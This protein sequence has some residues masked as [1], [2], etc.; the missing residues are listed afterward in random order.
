MTGWI[1]GL[2]LMPGPET[3][4]ILRVFFLSQAS[5]C[6][7]Q[8]LSLS[9]AAK[10]SV[11]DIYIGVL[12]HRCIGGPKS[13]RADP[14]AIAI[15]AIHASLSPRSRCLAP[16]TSCNSLSFRQFERADLPGTGSRSQSTRGAR[17]DLL[18]RNLAGENT[19]VRKTNF[20]DVYADPLFLFARIPH[21]FSCK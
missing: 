21:S 5:L 10:N 4:M 7:A 14:V 19:H 17:E 13:L 3:R 11:T 18:D 15:P 6:T 8:A 12:V 2:V 20:G 1:E 9:I 16:N